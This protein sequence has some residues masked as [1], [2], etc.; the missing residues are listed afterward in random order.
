MALPVDDRRTGGRFNEIIALLG[1][2]PGRREFATRQALICALT[3]L[4]VQIYQTPDAALTVYLVFFLNR[5]DRAT[6]LIMNMIMLLVMTTVITLVIVITMFVIDQPVWRV[7]SIAILSFV[8]LFLTSASKLRPL[9]ATIALIAGYAL[10]L[11]GANHSGEVATRALLY[12]WLF[13]AIPAGVSIAVNLLIAPAP[14]RLA[15]RALGERLELC[16]AML[17]SPDAATRAA[18]SANL[19]EGPAEVPAWLKLAAAEKT[20]RPSDIAALRQAMDSTTAILLLV[21]LV[22]QGSEALL[23]LN[24]RY[25]IAHLLDEM[26]S[27]LRLGGYPEEIVFDATEDEEKL[28]AVAAALLADLRDALTRFAEPSP[29]IPSENP[30]A[31]PDGGF[32]L[33]DA[34]SNPEHV[35][36][37]LKTTAAAMFC[38]G[39]YL[40]LDWPGIHTSFLTCYIVALPTTAETV[41]K[42]TLRI[43][44]CVLGAAIGIAAIVFVIASL[45][46]IGSLMA[47][48]FFGAFGAAWVAGGSPRISYAGFQIAFAFFLCVIQGPA[49]AFDMQTARDRVIGILIGNIVI[50]LVFIHVWPVS[51]A[52]RIDP[53]IG[54]LLR[55][56]STLA[57]TASLSGRRAVASGSLTAYGAVERDLGLLAFEPGSIRPSPDWLEKRSRALRETAS[58]IGPLLLAADRSPDGSA[59]FARRLDR[60]ADGLAPDGSVPNSGGSQAAPDHDLM[61]VGNSRGLWGLVNEPLTTLERTIMQPIARE[62]RLDHAQA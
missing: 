35:Q 3:T 33:G 55:R 50:S 40:M 27:I 23:P 53:A 38:Y 18:F 17:R 4:V 44:G 29:S 24:L 58:L 49:P 5:A 11:L 12:A 31:K 22:T 32:F 48:V 62:G 56:L 34:F 14:R 28:P 21:D 36:Y 39:L 37:A 60:L 20:S 52:R 43:L 47:L 6:S 13:V 16:A 41:E 8:L 54:A 25:R 57:Q 26:A 46:S 51:V 59:A 2:S 30:A 10:D 42:L 7:A 15:E 19:L 45:T 1:P 61:P 9:G